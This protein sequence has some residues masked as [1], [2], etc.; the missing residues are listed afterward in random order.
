MITPAEI[1][2]VLLELPAEGQADFARAVLADA[3]SWSAYEDRFL[4]TDAPLGEVRELLELL[5]DVLPENHK[6]ESE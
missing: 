1:T 3:G 4:E 6:G 5:D 2:A